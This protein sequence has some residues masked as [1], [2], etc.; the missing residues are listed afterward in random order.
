MKSKATGEILKSAKSYLAYLCKEYGFDI[1][2]VKCRRRDRSLVDSRVVIAL[3]M[4]G[5]GY[6]YPIIGMAM[7]RDHTSIMH[8]VK[9]GVR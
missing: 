5:A 9:R 2:L 3:K 4:R 8:L 1:N 6:S 7:D